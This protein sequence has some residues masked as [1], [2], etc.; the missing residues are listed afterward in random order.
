M[1]I[2]S[3]EVEINDTF[4]AYVAVH[5]NITDSIAP[6]FEIDL[7]KTYSPNGAII[8]ITNAIVNMTVSGT[9]SVAISNNDGTYT[10]ST[11]PTD[12]LDSVIT[13]TQKGVGVYWPGT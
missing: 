11:L 13:T 6:N 10:L 3:Q 1:Y 8:P 4:E 5:M 12:T 7:W 9:P 2:K